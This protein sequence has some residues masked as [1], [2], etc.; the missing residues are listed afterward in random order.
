MERL[1]DSM[2]ER[3][4]GMMR[5]CQLGCKWDS[6]SSMRKMICLVGGSPR[7]FAALLCSSHAQTRKYDNAMIAEKVSELIKQKREGAYWDFKQEWHSNKASL[8]HDILCMANNL[9]DEDAFIIA[10]PQLFGLEPADHDLEEQAFVLAQKFEDKKLDFAIEYAI[11]K[12]DW[13]IPLYIKEGLEWLCHNIGADGE[14][15]GK[16]A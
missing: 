1:N 7:N 2:T 11:N 16:N 13:E 6:I 5:R 12:T 8:L 3:R 15:C 14:G 10:N 4:E 9:V